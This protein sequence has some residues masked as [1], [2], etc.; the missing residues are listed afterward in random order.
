MR[1]RQGLIEVP[2]GEDVVEFLLRDGR[3]APPREPE[4][5]ALVAFRD[6][7]L[8][9]H[10]ASLEPRT[11]SGIELH[12]KHIASRLGDAFQIRKLGLAD[13]QGY[14]DARSRARHRGRTIS[15]ATIRK[16]FVSLKTAWNWAVRMGLVAG[17]FPS[18]G[19]RFPRSSEKSP[20]MTRAE[21]ER[22]L[23]EG[24]LTDRQAA[25]AWE[26]L[27]LKT[28]G[29]VEALEIVKARAYHAW[30]YAMACMA[31][32]AGARRSE[33]IRMRT[34]D[35]EFTAGSVLVRE[36]KRVKGR[37]STRRVPLTPLL[38]GVLGEWLAAHPGGP[39][40]FCHSSVVDRSG[41]RGRKTRGR[42]GS[43][44]SRDEAHDHLKRTLAGSR[45]AVIRG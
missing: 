25:G 6:R 14:V 35:V 31:A 39:W 19:L 29:I 23:A 36:K 38:V 37:D 30:I 1:L 2:P 8:E 41:T 10:R 5:P 28:D 18:D 42:A 9:T 45:W 22:R 13:L 40:L 34:S 20:F 43:P 33:P 16:E 26:A 27:Y 15:P 17:R 12:F 21:I 24:G 3:A 7:S 44:L 32:H 11:V 4:S